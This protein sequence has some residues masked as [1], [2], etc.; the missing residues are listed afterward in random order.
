MR[1]RF[2]AAFSLL[3]GAGALAVSGRAQQSAAPQTAQEP[4]FRSATHAVSVYAT[5]VDPSGRLVPNL[6]RDDFEIYDNGIKQDLT[7]FDNGIQPITIVI[8]LDR[9]GSMVKNFDLERDAAVQFV[10]NLLPKDKA[11]L[12]SF[13][14]RIEIDPATFT[15][16]KDELIRILHENLLD[17][18]VTPLWNATSAAM[19]ALEHQEGR[20]VVLVFTDGYDNPEQPDRHTESFHDVLSRAEGDEVMVYAIGLATTCG[21]PAIATADRPSADPPTGVVPAAPLFQRGMPPPKNPPMPGIPRGPDNGGAPPPPNPGMPI[22]GGGIPLGPGVSMPL[23][24]LLGR[25]HTDTGCSDSKPDPSLKDLA[26]EGG[27]GYF[28]L[29]GTDDLGSTFARVADELHHQYLLAF[30]PDKLDGRTHNLEVRV[31]QPGLTIRARR[32]YVASVDR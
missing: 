24:K 14:N 27:G 31:R 11:R 19:L 9:S 3:A 4:S 20:R 6:T 16:D 8:M 30:K 25:R 22:P 28:E 1:R 29:H 21:S 18:G 5:V 32:T 15:S 26:A 12:G 10:A 17:A 2:L 23:D 7:L 13:S